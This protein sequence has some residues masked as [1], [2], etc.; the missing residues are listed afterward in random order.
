L[1]DVSYNTAAALGRAKLD[2]QKR[3]ADESYFKVLTDNQRSANLKTGTMARSRFDKAPEIGAEG[4]PIRG[5]RKM[6]GNRLPVRV[7][8]DNESPEKAMR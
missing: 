4:S 8:L 1:A 5:G 6:A 2:S 3:I 7:D